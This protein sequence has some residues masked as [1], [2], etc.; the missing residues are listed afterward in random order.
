MARH[1]YGSAND[2]IVVVDQASADG[3]K[4]LDGLAAA[5]R[6]LECSRPVPTTFSESVGWGCVVCSS[7]PED[8]AFTV[9]ASRVPVLGVLCPACV[10]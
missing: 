7:H 4:N 8:A 1:F 3:A 2:P 5:E 6:C 9:A 10:V